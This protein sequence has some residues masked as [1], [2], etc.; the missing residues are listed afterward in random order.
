MNGF[1]FCSTLL[2]IW[3]QISLLSDCPRN[4]SILLN[5]SVIIALIF[6]F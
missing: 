5:R 2:L 6:A 3:K 4:H 1:L